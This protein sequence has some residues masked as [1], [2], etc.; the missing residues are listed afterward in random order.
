MKKNEHRPALRY[1]C[2]CCVVF[3]PHQPGKGQLHARHI[4]TLCFY[5]WKHMKVILFALVGVNAENAWYEKK[6][7]DFHSRRNKAAVF[8]ETSVLSS[9]PP[10]PLHPLQCP[11][12][13]L[14]GPLER[15]SPLSHVVESQ[16]QCTASTAAECLR[17]LI[18]DAFMNCAEA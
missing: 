13:P 2:Q 12:R 11:V 16:Q 4:L 9:V 14:Q 6:S 1:S 15:P 18:F 17:G 7:G 8:D 3:W 5:I 10:L